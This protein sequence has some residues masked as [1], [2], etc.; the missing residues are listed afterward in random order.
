VRVLGVLAEP[1]P[2]RASRIP[3]GVPER[4]RPLLGALLEYHP[5]ARVDLVVRA[6][7]R[8][9]EAH[10]GQ[11]RKTGEP[12]I[13]HPLAVASI[14]ADL[15]L[16]DSTLAAALLHDTVEDTP[17]SLETIRR[18]FGPEIAALVDGVTKLD[19]IRF[20]SRE[21]HKAETLRKMFLA[22]AR[23]LRV[24]MIKLADRLHNLR[25][26]SPL[27][28]EKQQAIA[29]ETLELYAPV[30]HRLGID[31]I[32][33]E[34][35]DLAFATLEPQRFAEIVEMVRE[36]QPEREKYLAKVVETVKEALRAA[37]IK[38]EVTGRPKHVYSVYE[39]MVTK[40]RSFDE[41]YD[42][43]GVRIIVNTVRECYSALGVVHSLWTPVPGRFKDYVAMPKFNMYQS[44]H[45][46][47]VGPEGK[48]LEIQ[49]RTQAMH[50]MAEYGV[51]AHWR[52]KGKEA[53]RGKITEV[54][55]LK[56]FLDWQQELSDP[57]EFLEGL[58]RDLYPDE[59][60]VFTPKGD[61]VSLPAGATPIDFAY[62]IHTEVGHACVGAK[63]DGRIVPLDYQLK[64]GETVEIITSRAPGA[65]PS[66]DWLQV[67]KT[68]RARSKIKQWFS[69]EL[70]EEALEQ[71]RDALMRAV[72]RAG[73]P[74]RSTLGRP[75]EEAALALG[76][77]DTDS[78]YRAV[79]EGRVSPQTVLQRLAQRLA[80][81]E[82]EP[83]EE[84]RPARATAE[85]S[86]ILVQGEP[87]VLVHLARC[88][89]PLPPDP[90]VGFVTR[91]RGIS[92]HRSDCPNAR[93]LSRDSGRLVEVAWDTQR[94]GA[95]QVTIQVEAFD[96]TKLLRDVSHAISETGVNITSSQTRTNPR[97]RSAVLRFTVELADLS[98][99]SAILANVR[100]V[101]SVYDAYR[102]L[103][104]GARGRS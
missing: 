92:V 31:R 4:L 41:I 67:V 84:E 43:V 14:L 27:P 5:G 29:R 88:C 81:E 51:A 28:P 68:A 25:T 59:V 91:G 45:T 48:P 15:G 23:D 57:K 11:V 58:R 66:R 83:P 103:P 7:A 1:A 34:L 47:V 71:G 75:L 61:V 76:Y 56:S 38:A 78:L 39:K 73:L 96:R 74:L 12:Y 26:I 55:W 13:E 20:A 30:A 97:T 100:K 104:S 69:R 42:L 10:R 46:T 79:G 37:R 93:A 102:V 52:Y 53:R 49:I 54:A 95:F 9:E 94:R 17:L 87:G 16:D 70:K 44:L 22:M 65:G 86:G 40:G 18:E 90:V 63:V 3:E 77:E 82:E 50:R 101:D 32:R 21:E 99:L 64:T 89:T 62:A 72:R 6:F 8:A 85:G 24:V 80:A 60:F 35:E 98:H 19:R 33:W 2:E 36:R